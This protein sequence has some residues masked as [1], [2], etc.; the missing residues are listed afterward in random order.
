MEADKIIDNSKNQ[1][2][3]SPDQQLTERF[4]ERLEEI[5]L[6]LKS[7]ELTQKE[8]VE[9]KKIME[10]KQ[11]APADLIEA[12]LVYL[13]YGR[14][15]IRVMQLNIILDSPELITDAIQDLIINH[16]LYTQRYSVLTLPIGG[17]NHA[18][19]IIFDKSDHTVYYFDPANHKLD[20][21]ADQFITCLASALGIEFN[22][23]TFPKGTKQ[24]EDSSS[25]QLY[26][27]QNVANFFANSLPYKN[28]AQ[29]NLQASKLDLKALA[30]LLLKAARFGKPLI[31]EQSFINQSN[32]RAKIALRDLLKSDSLEAIRDER[33]ISH[34]YEALKAELESDTPE[35]TQYRSLEKFIDHYKR[36]LNNKRSRMTED[37]KITPL[38]DA[39]EHAEDFQVKLSLNGLGIKNNSDELTTQ[40]RVML[41]GYSERFTQY[42]DEGEIEIEIEVEPV[43][44]ESTRKFVISNNVL[45]PPVITEQTYNPLSLKESIFKK[46]SKEII[47]KRFSKDIF[48]KSLKEIEDFE[49]FTKKDYRIS[50]PEALWEDY[51]LYIMNYN[52]EEEDIDQV[53]AKHADMF[54]HIDGNVYIDDEWIL[55]TYDGDETQYKKEIT[56]A[57]SLQTLTAIRSEI[58]ADRTLNKQKLTKYKQKI[59]DTATITKLKE[60]T[61]RAGSKKSWERIAKANPTPLPDDLI[62]DFAAYCFY[63][64]LSAHIKK[65]NEKGSSYQYDL[66]KIRKAA[67]EHSAASPGKFYQTFEFL[68]SIGFESEADYWW[69][70]HAKDYFKKSLPEKNTL[71]F[72]NL[73]LNTAREAIGE[74]LHVTQFFIPFKKVA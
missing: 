60:I 8:Q 63:K 5:K 21:V 30:I 17:G 55:Y 43:G 32:F 26:G 1:Q 61:T 47:F 46:F 65:E 9:Y 27:I 57:T 67:Q 33:P 36:G 44:D 14:D 29:L 62:E 13:F 18:V 51:Y 22:I 58:D 4:K 25:C 40:I 66:S 52:P 34:L 54:V 15:D 53:I 45:N 7:I 56:N 23:K 10:D 70:T 74:G 39:C 3:P 41:P 50:F 2:E 38:L 20:P 19:Y 16:G 72:E 11:G 71:L 35:I 37:P 69:G 59:T 28:A 73:L 49:T 6:K 24:Q 48:N 12:A 68:A 42:F 64:F 31:E